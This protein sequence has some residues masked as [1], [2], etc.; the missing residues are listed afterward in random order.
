MLKLSTRPPMTWITLLAV[1][2]PTWSRP[3]GRGAARDH[4][5]AAGSYTMCQSTDLL[6]S[7]LSPTAP[8][9]PCSRPFS[10]T[11]ATEPQAVG[12]D[13]IRRHWSCAPLQAKH[14]AWGL[15]FCSVKPP[16]ANSVSPSTATPTWLAPSGKGAALRHASRVGS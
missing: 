1:T 4:R 3:V 7:K 6:V 15:R 5:S 14:S 9:M 11:Q 10:T 16:I 2:A 8:P 13:A 12:S